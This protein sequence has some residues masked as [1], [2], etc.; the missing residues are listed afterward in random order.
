MSTLSAYMISF[1][2]K[3]ENELVNMD[4]SFC[5][6]D[7]HVLGGLYL[8]AGMLLLS[9]FGEETNLVEV[10]GTQCIVATQFITSNTPARHLHRI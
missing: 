4:N 10:S 8:S 3:I 2:E 5:H 6:I 7:L 9:S 1:Q